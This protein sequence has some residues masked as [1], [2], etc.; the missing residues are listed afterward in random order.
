[1]TLYKT[2]NFRARKPMLASDM[3]LADIPLREY[4]VWVQPKLDG[5]RCLA[6]WENNRLVLQSRGGKEWILP[7]I[8]NELQSLMRLPESDVLDG[9][10]YV[11]GVPRQKL[12]QWLTKDSADT[13][14]VEYHVFDKP[15][16]WVDDPRADWEY[17]V[18][19][20]DQFFHNFKEDKVKLVPT[21]KADN[22]T[23]VVE[24]VEDFQS[25]GYEGG[26]VR[27]GSGHYAWSL[28]SKKLIKVKPLFEEEFTIVNF[29]E[30]GGKHAGCIVFVCETSEGKRFNVVPNWG[31]EE[32]RA[33][34]CAGAKYVG[35]RLS[36]R[37]A[38]QS[39]SGIPLQA[40][41]IA[42]RIDL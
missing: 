6:F 37:F 12:Q 8:T 41:G 9:E 21:H 5:V 16:V 3:P 1:M 13:L 15:T 17:R 29:F 23:K 28:R 42:V 25:R 19:D 40:K 22:L 39:I 20:L 14:R 26:M 11:H 27:L 7:H 24:L 31:D 32:R 10:L 36:T 30:A 18:K 4:P 38:G 35:E 33:A 34:L 2:P